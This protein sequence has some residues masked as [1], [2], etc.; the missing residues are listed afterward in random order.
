MESLCS[1]PA[2]P[3]DKSTPETVN[4]IL[5]FQSAQKPLS[6][7]GKGKMRTQHPYTVIYFVYLC[8]KEAY[9]SASKQQKIKGWNISITYTNWHKPHRIWKRRQCEWK[10]K[11]WDMGQREGDPA[12]LFST[13]WYPPSPPK[14]STLLPSLFYRFTLGASASSVR[15]RKSDLRY[16]PL[17]HL[18]QPYRQRQKTPK[19]LMETCRS[20][21]FSMKTTATLQTLRR[22]KD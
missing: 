22:E 17:F 21:S 2:V 9:L 1:Q 11:I 3:G 10:T 15:E 5:W 18:I 19:K 20:H 16:F 14:T 6:H 7:A 8:A 4:A 13:P 12:S